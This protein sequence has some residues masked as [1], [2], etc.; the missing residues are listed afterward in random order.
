[1]AEEK[2]ERNERLRQDV[3]GGMA[4]A[5]AARK[6]K[7]SRERVRQIAGNIGKRGPK[8]KK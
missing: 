3:E 8:G 5:D 7:V 6:Y 1:M 4:P 2:K